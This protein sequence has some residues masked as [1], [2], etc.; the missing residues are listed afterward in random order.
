VELNQFIVGRLSLVKP[1]K[2]RGNDASKISPPFG[3]IPKNGGEMPKGNTSQGG[4]RSGDGI[5]ETFH[6]VR[7]VCFLRQASPA[8]PSQTDFGSGSFSRRAPAARHLCRIRIHLAN[9]GT[10]A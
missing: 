10:T 9:F 4:Q 8:H 6:R 3:L 5:K 2:N 7:L 1:D